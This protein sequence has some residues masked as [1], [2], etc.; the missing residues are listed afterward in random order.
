[1]D[2]E[3]LLHVTGGLHHAEEPDDDEFQRELE[4]GRVEREIQQVGC[5]TSAP[6][7]PVAKTSGD[8]RQVTPLGTCKTNNV[9]RPTKTSIAVDGAKDEECRVLNQRMIAMLKDQSKAAAESEKQSKLIASLNTRL[10][11]EL[12]ANRDLANRLKLAESQINMQKKEMILLQRS[13]TTNVAPTSVDTRLQR[14]LEE[15]NALRAKQAGDG[16]SP[17][18]DSAEVCN[19]NLRNENK[20]LETHRVELLNVL[21]KQGKLIDIL[22]RQKLHLEAAKLLQITEEEFVKVLEVT[23]K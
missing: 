15:I 9:K 17:G 20:R 12:A 4:D 13:T 18:T 5:H 19:T 6:V 21:R 3:D 16:G 22:K 2:D 14:A 23:Q 1:M 8:R 10:D 11:K 7:V